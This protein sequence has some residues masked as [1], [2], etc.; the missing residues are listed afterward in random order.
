LENVTYTSRFALGLFYKDRLALKNGEGAL[1][2]VADDAVL[3]YWTL[4]NE[5]RILDRQDQ[6]NEEKD[7]S[8]VV[9][10]TT[11][12]FGADNVEKS[13]DEMKTVLMKEIDGRFKTLEGPTPDHI[14]CH[15]WRY[16]QVRITSHS[17][18]KT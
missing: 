11:T 2:Y 12:K 13:L 3:R 1:N 14:K 7:P 5:K 18:S 8:S 9:I 4:E 10:H 16:S 15:K 6:G 17:Y